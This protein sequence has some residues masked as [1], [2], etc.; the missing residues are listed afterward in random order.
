MRLSTAA[1]AALALALP[2]RALAYDLERDDSGSTIRWNKTFTLYVD[3]HSR[4]L[5]HQ[6]VLDAAQRAIAHWAAASAVQ[7]EVQTE[8]SHGKSGY[9]ASRGDNRS[10]LIFVSDE[11]EGDDSVVATT[12]VTTDTTTHEILDADILVNEAEHHFAILPDDAQPGQGLSTDFEGTL[13]HELGHALGLAHN[14][15]LPEATMYPSTQVGEITKRKLAADDVSGVQQLY[16]APGN[17]TEPPEVPAG[18]TSGV[19]QDGA[20]ALAAV[21]LALGSR[22]RRAR[23]MALASMAAVVLAPSLARAEPVVTQ[24]VEGQVVS[25]RGYWKDGRIYTD[26]TV[27]V[28]RCAGS[29]CAAQLTFRQ[30]GGTVGNLSQQLG[31]LKVPPAGAHLQV[32]LAPA[33]DGVLRLVPGR[34]R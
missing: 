5:Q 19:G 31:D 17:P 6:E 27:A 33:H 18:C 23:A 14:A 30:P 12:L 29:S 1:V 7:I 26:V 21:L 25:T 4:D 34:R 24:E 3:A 20:F 15:D 10:E 16:G 2:G 9:D 22:L 13:T 32:R 8:G 11:W 28:Q